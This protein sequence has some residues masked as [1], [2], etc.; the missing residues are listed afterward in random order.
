MQQH[1]DVTTDML[2][3]NAKRYLA[4]YLTISVSELTNKQLQTDLERNV[5]VVDRCTLQQNFVF[6]FHFHEH[7]PNIYNCC[8]K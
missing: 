3:L 2:K 4:K 1:L 5:F 7:F 6:F 8:I